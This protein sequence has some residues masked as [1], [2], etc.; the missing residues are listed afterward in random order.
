M[1][2]IMILHPPCATST[3]TTHTPTERCT[4]NLYT[5]AHYSP[6]WL[7]RRIYMHKD[8]VARL[9]AE[10]TPAF[11]TGNSI[12]TLEEVN[13]LPTP[14]H[15]SMLS[16]TK[17][18]DF[19]PS[20]HPTEPW[21]RIPPWVATPSEWDT[22]SFVRHTLST[23]CRNTLAKTRGNSILSGLEPVLAKG[24]PA[25][26]K[27]VR[28]FGGAVESQE[29][30]DRRQSKIYVVRSIQCRVGWSGLVGGGRACGEWMD[31]F[32]SCTLTFPSRHDLGHRLKRNCAISVSLSI[33]TAQLLH[34]QPISHPPLFPKP[35]YANNPKSKS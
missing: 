5:L 20:L 15:S 16:T 3:A 13:H 25:D 17:P 4:A 24:T 32:V 18:S 27:M 22:T 35:H 14:A 31:R 12:T 11:P 7:L 34:P 8:A 9:R 21:S 19:I 10:I 6:Y 29:G 30:A 23:T 2:H 26:L 33:C 1:S 28:A